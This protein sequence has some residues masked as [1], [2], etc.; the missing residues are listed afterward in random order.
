LKPY[1]A[2]IFFNINDRFQQAL[3]HFKAAAA[4]Y[5]KYDPNNYWELAQCYNFVG[6]T[7]FELANIN[8]LLRF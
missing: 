6:A 1:I 5:E 4:F 8:L 3:E 2:R 7:Y